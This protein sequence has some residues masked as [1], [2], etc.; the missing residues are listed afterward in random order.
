MPTDTNAVAER[1]MYELLG[2]RWVWPAL[3][4]TEEYENVRTRR[5]HLQGR[6]IISVDDLTLGGVEVTDYAIENHATIR[7]PRNCGDCLYYASQ[8]WIWTGQGPAYDAYIN[9]DPCATLV[10]SY[11]YGA[12]PPDQVG[13]AIDALQCELDKAYANDDECRLPDRVTNISRQGLD[14]TLIDPQDFLTNGKTGLIEVDEALSFFNPSA[15]KTRA[16]V[17]SPDYLPG[18]RVA[19]GS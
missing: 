18:R 11:T 5:V 1:V 4:V 16:R 15:A 6:P 10:V 3:S 12:P 2:R 13:L 8:G 9:R 19:G 7:L 14:M 17:F